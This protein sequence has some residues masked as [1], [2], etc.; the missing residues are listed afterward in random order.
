MQ[1]RKTP[2]GLLLQYLHFPD[3]FV[4]RRE[5]SFFFGPVEESCGCDLC[6]RLVKNIFYP[7]MAMNHKEF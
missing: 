6:M 4:L 7:I 1:I 5:N 3:A 2:E